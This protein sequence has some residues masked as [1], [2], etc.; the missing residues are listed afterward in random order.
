M[1]MLRLPYTSM[2]LVESVV[3]MKIRHGNQRQK[4]V[5]I[6]RYRGVPP[7]QEFLSSHQ[8]SSSSAHHL[9]HPTSVSSRQHANLLWPVLRQ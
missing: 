3:G 6:F 2:D 1:H 9:K 8:L 4:H 7:V 5:V